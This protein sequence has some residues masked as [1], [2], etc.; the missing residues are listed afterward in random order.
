MAKRRRVK[1]GAIAVAIIFI[2]FIIGIIAFFSLMD[3]KEPKKEAEELYVNITFD[4]DGGTEVP[5]KKIKAGETVKLPN[6][7][8]EGFTFS[9]WFDGEDK[10]S[11]ETT[12]GKDTTLKAKWEEE[13]TFKI[14][15]DSNGGSKINP[16]TV[17]CNRKL[18]LPEEPSKKGYT[19]IKWTEKKDKKDKK[20]DG[21]ETAKEV[22]DGQLLPCEDIT[23]IANW[24]KEK[25]NTYTVT[26]DSKG[27]SK[28]S[29]ITVDCDKTITLP[30]TPTRDGYTFVSWADINGKVILDGAL[31]Y[32]EDVTLYANW[33]KKEEVVITPAPTPEATPTPVPVTPTPEPTPVPATPPPEPTSSTQETE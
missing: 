6:S 1:K 25:T 29:S 16:I 3:K 30:K 33:E 20:D 32:C 12:Y 10:V 7:E 22:L 18:E 21:E 9:G 31:L 19:F 24:E 26:F 23:L 4:S 11:S 8:K 28:V 13:K 2:L 17:I 15:F 5:N 27:G 14:T